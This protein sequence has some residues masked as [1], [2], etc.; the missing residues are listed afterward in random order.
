MTAPEPKPV[1]WQ[2]PP[3]ATV[4]ALDEAMRAVADRI[5]ADAATLEAGDLQ[6][7][8]YCAWNIAAA[9]ENLSPRSSA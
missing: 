6:A 8:G 1:T 9:R 4:A 2:V 7:L 5:T 3:L